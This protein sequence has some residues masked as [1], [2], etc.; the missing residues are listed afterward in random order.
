[1]LSCPNEEEDKRREGQGRDGDA[2][3][4]MGNVMSETIFFL[5]GGLGAGLFM[6]LLLAG[7]GVRRYYDAKAIKTLKEAG[8]EV[9]FET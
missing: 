7:I 3:I 4:R 9:E 8:Y 2:N 1:M 5:Y 6:F